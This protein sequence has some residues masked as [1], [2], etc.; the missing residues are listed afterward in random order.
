MAK[1][2]EEEKR[3]RYQQAQNHRLDWASKRNA[4]PQLTMRKGQL[5]RSI[6]V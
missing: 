5:V 6:N 1:M 3:A 2:T 4:E